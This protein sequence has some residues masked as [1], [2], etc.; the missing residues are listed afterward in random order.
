MPSEEQYRGVGAI[1]FILVDWFLI[2]PIVIW[3]FR[4]G[5]AVNTLEVRSVQRNT[6]GNSRLT[7]NLVVG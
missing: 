2:V 4:V 1:P 5:H 7:S 3:P 6:T